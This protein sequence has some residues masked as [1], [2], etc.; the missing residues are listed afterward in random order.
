MGRCNEVLQ[1]T[2]KH[3]VQNHNREIL[4]NIIHTH[5]GGYSSKY[6]GAQIEDALGQVMTQHVTSGV[7]ISSTGQWFRIAECKNSIA[8]P[9]A[10]MLRLAT[11]WHVNQPSVCMFACAVSDVT[12]A[13]KTLIA[14]RRNTDDYF[15]AIRCQLVNEQCYI[16]VKLTNQNNIITAGIALHNPSY[17]SVLPHI[18]A[19]PAGG[20]TLAEYDIQYID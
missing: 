13:C 16:D 15:S 10:F 19:A 3:A 6:S 20:S 8:A 11:V 18:E 5:Y 14:M 1:S 12:F 4:Y 9:Q 17:V 7:A 2:S